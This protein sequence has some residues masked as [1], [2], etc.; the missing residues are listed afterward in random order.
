LIIVATPDNEA[1][2]AAPYL[3]AQAAII[4]ASIPAKVVALP[5]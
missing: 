5:E 3:A 4:A 1:V 2:P